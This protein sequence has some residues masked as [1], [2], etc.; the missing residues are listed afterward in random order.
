M[1]PASDE[2]KELTHMC[3][4]RFTGEPGHETEVTKY[5]IAN[6]NTEDENVEEEKVNIRNQ[7]I[8]RETTFFSHSV[9]IT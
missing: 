3:Q 5:S 4:G 6:E 8:D 2:A 1:T 7:E 9:S